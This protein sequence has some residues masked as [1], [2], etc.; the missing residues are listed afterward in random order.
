VG[1]WRPCAT[2]ELVVVEVAGDGFAGD[3]SGPGAIGAVTVGWVAVAAAVGVAAAAGAVYDA[4][5]G[6]VA[7]VG[8]LVE[9]R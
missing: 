1:Y 9:A 8:D 3:F 4:A 7:Q 5:G 6:A 2:L